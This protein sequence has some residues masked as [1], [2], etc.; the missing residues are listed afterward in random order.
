MEDGPGSILTV[1]IWLYWAGVGVMV[2]RVRKRTHKAT[3]LVP[4]ERL[5]RLMWMIWVPLVM[6]W[7]VLPYLAMTQSHPLLALPRPTLVYPAFSTLRW[8]ASALAVFCLLLTISCWVRMGYNW[9]M[10]VVPDER[11]EPVTHGLY[12]RIRHPI[13]TLSMLLMLCSVLIVPT[14]PMIAVA[15][16]HI[17]L[18]ILKTRNEERFLL[19]L[20][21]ENYLKYCQRTGRFVPRL[22]S[23]RL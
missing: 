5:E 10:A 1:T 18:M 14:I 6:A 20:Y 9:R 11:T 8:I 2:F 7:I 21:G 13:Y 23:C 12:A 19:K 16:L 17:P 3:G 22:N 4:K 15:A